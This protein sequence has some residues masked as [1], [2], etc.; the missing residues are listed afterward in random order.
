M[1]A[2]R[3]VHALQVYNS[4]HL[5][6]VPLSGWARRPQEDGQMFADTRQAMRRGRRLCT[7]HAELFLQAAV[8]SIYESRADLRMP[9]WLSHHRRQNAMRTRAFY[10]EHE[11]N[12]ND[13]IDDINYGTRAPG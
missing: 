4:A 8:V 13:N 5:R 7:D 1:L 3:Q 9:G 6:Q 10:Y 12:N 11:H 2:G